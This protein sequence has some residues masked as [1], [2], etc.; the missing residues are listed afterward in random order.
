MND[1]G[2]A[3]VEVALVVPLLAALALCLVWVAMIGA[4]QIA[5]VDAGRAA[6]R[7][8]SVGGDDAACRVAAVTA[9]PGL[10]PARMDLRF[11]RSGGQVRVRVRYREAPPLAVLG[12]LV[13][14]MTLEDE[15]ISPDESDETVENP[16]KATGVPKIP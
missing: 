12:R 7:V 13:A 6:V 14:P 8:A 15:E 9:A 3:T 1:R 4:H 10:D 5:I 11:T 2:Q 16:S